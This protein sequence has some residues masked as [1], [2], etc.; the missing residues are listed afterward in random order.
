M[1]PHPDPKPSNLM[2]FQFKRSF[3][4]SVNQHTT[5]AEVEAT[6]RTNVERVIPSRNI[7]YHRRVLSLGDTL[8]DAIDLA[9]KEL[10]ETRAAAARSNAPGAGNVRIGDVRT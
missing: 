1:L 6:V 2:S 7:Q 9:N 3:V 5:Q 4:P 8:K 10:Q